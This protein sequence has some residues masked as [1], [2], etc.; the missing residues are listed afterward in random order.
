M[1]AV[2]VTSISQA[3][4]IK[5]FDSCVWGL[6]ITCCLVKAWQVCCCASE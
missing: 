2:F 4:H 1:S 6:G 3:V 5:Q